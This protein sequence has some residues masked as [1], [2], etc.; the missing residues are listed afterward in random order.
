MCGLDRIR[1]TRASGKRGTFRALA[2][3]NG[4]GPKERVGGGTTCGL[5]GESMRHAG[6]ARGPFLRFFRRGRRRG[7]RSAACLLL[8]AFLSA[9]VLVAPL[10]AFAQPDPSDQP[11]Q[12]VPPPVPP[13]WNGR[14]PP[15]PPGYYGPPPGPPVVIA[16][17]PPPVVVAPAPPPPLSTPA[18]IFY[19]PFYAVGLVLRYGLYYLV[20][21]PFEVLGRALSFGPSGGVDY[22]PP[23]PQPP[24]NPPASAA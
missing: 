24:P 20:V 4:M 7:R 3:S 2:C 22:P 21:A 17:V 6:N 19:A 10:A 13:G 8:V 18:K 11:A 12:P 5:P 15:P 23:P 14:P 16:P 9:A 1:R